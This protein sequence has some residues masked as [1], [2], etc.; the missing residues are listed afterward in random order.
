M[1]TGAAAAADGISTEKLPHHQG[2]TTEHNNYET[3]EEKF[4]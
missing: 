2:G 4:H 1:A 3:T